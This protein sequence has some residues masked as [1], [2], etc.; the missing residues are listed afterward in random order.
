MS[1]KP[2]PGVTTPEQS[3]NPTESPR[4]R[5]TL[6]RAPRG[7]PQPLLQI[8][9]W[10]RILGPGLVTGA[11]DDDPSGIGTY[12]QAGAAFGTAQ[13][14]LALYMLPLLIAV[15]EMCA[16]IGLVT[17]KGLSAVVRQHY[18]RRVLYVA[19]GLVLAANILNIGA[20]LG[21]MAATVELL[22]PGIPFLILLIALSL[23]ILALEVFVPYRSYAVVLKVLALSLFA[24]VA[25][26]LIVGPSGAALV[27]A[28]LVP[29]IQLT[30]TFLA[31]V[32]GVLGTTISPYLFFWQASEE[33]EEIT[34]HHREP[35]GEDRVRQR[36]VL[37]ARIR[38]L[39]LDTVLGML[40]S[41][42]ATWFII[43]TTGSVLH[44]HGITNITTADQAAAALAPLVH[45]FPHAGVLA[46]VIFAVGILGVGLLGIPVLA[47][48]AAYAVAEA[49]HWKEGLAK[50]FLQA[51]GFYIVIGIATL[52]GMLL[53]L[54][55][56][57]PISALV[58]S[59]V[60]NGIVAIPLLVLILLV[61]NNRTVMQ[62]HVNGR[63]ANGLGILTTLAMAAAVVALVVSFFWR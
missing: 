14:W 5:T 42:V 43:F 53:N 59:A 9:R 41:E 22:A 12:S 60:I 32:V 21:A 13:L 44:N 38:S 63:L 34:L 3:A 16:R 62:A 20:D 49:F 1:M 40:S 27:R 2:Q 7:R 52:V 33:V 46:K 29:N 61:A 36:Q 31:L 57:N 50:T 18:S 37:L 35:H 47:G 4:L 15:Q 8:R 6:L 28:T 30:P 58:Y 24:Y 56:I 55:G 39:R 51:P 10:L 11:A 26:G 17:G 48:S 54:L 19:V 25:T 23:G 45:T